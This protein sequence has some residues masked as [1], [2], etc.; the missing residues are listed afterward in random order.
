MPVW[1]ADEIE[2]ALCPLLRH[3]LKDNVQMFLSGEIL[4]VCKDIDDRILTWPMSE[5]RLALTFRHTSKPKRKSDEVS[6]T[7]G[8]QANRAAVVAAVLKCSSPS[9]A[10]TNSTLIKSQRD[11]NLDAAYNTRSPSLMPPPLTLFHDVSYQFL[12][13]YSTPTDTME[14]TANELDE[15]FDFVMTSSP[16]NLLRRRAS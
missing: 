10:A 2:A 12:Q 9:I 16:Y 6:P 11:E 5:L 1:S 8:T 15:S 14:F 13:E 7:L 3:G 4:P